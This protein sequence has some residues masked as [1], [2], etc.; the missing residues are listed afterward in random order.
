MDPLLPE[1]DLF[2]DPS[3]YWYSDKFGLDPQEL[4]TTLHDRFNTKGFPLQDPQAF[5]QDV[6]ECADN[7]E[8]LD[9]FYSKLGDRKAQRMK[10]M[11]DAWEEVTTW[12]S[13]LP[14]NMFCQLCYDKES[15][16]VKLDPNSLNDGLGERGYAFSQ[17]TR[18][19]SFDSMVIFFDGFARDER[20]EYEESERRK[21]NMPDCPGKECAAGL[22]AAAP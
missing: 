9:Q 2:L 10:E 13:A 22:L 16:D 19:M 4:F 7:A 15:K 14:K 3:W 12:L 11:N 21:Q 1:I 17:F 20:R 6:C 8:T 18:T 5:H